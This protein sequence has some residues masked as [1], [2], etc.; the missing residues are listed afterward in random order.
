MA[1][2][3]NENTKFANELPGNDFSTSNKTLPKNNNML[4]SSHVSIT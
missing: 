3:L 1:H 4:E 2:D